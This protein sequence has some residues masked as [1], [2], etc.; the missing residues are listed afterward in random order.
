MLTHLQIP[1]SREATTDLYTVIS[2]LANPGAFLA[3]I[4]GD[5]APFNCLVTKETS[6]LIDFEYGTYAHALL[7]GAQ[8]RMLFPSCG[9]V[10][11][12]PASILQEIETTYHNGLMQGCPEAADDALFAQ[13]LT[14]ACAY[15]AINF[16]SWR[17]FLQTMK[18]DCTWGI[19]TVRQLHI[20]RAERFAQTTQETG[21]FQALGAIFNEVA[22]QLRSLWPEATD[23]LPLYP[24]FRQWA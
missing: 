23:N 21:Y 16:C 7:D 5:P 1:S 22:K 17:S 15:W 3:Y 24:A 19:S 10:N 20:L 6:Y 2:L 13:A 18:E 14:A 8:A 11:H 4:H 9:F 12:I